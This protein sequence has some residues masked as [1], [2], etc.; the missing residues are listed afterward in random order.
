[1]SSPSC[2]D[3]PHTLWSDS[4]SFVA[5]MLLSTHDT[6]VVDSE[7]PEVS[8]ASVCPEFLLNDER[9]EK[10]ARDT[11]GR[12][13]HTI[14]SLKSTR[15]Y[16]LPSQWQRETVQTKVL[17]TKSKISETLSKGTI[18]DSVCSYFLHGNRAVK[19]AHQNARVHSLQFQTFSTPANLR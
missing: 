3:S 7:L 14:L 13:T 17:F 15:W 18:H 5:E 19:V 4:P 10:R 1:M 11:C 6:Q 9:I 8:L 12:F 2:E 16:V